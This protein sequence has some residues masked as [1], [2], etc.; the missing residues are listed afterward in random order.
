MK[1][2][3]FKGGIEPSI[4]DQMYDICKPKDI[5]KETEAI[6]E[7]KRKLNVLGTNLNT[8]FVESLENPIALFCIAEIYKE[9]GFNS[10]CGTVI[11]HC[12]DKFPS[13]FHNYITRNV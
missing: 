10:L 12:N 13:E 2:L 8:I 7:Q 5:A 11:D 1:D 9:L 6:A 3:N 4:I